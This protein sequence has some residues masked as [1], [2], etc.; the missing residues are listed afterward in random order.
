[1]QCKINKTETLG[2]QA[3]QPVAP[4][5]VSQPLCPP[6]ALEE[7]AFLQLSLRKSKIFERPK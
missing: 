1:M 3:C 6:A 5:R 7:I 4:S 2:K